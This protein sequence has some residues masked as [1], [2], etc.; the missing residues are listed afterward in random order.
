MDPKPWFEYSYPA[1]S[2]KKLV[3]IMSLGS[4]MGRGVVILPVETYLWY[5]LMFVMYLTGMKCM[6]KLPK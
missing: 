4:I 3:C 6:C 2:S 1:H 5:I